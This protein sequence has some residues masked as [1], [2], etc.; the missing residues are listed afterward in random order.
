[1][2]FITAFKKSYFI[3]NAIQGVTRKKIHTRYQVIR[4]TTE[5]NDSHFI[6]LPRI[7]NI[8]KLY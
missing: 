7:N 2:T 6:Q 3:D 4:M 1:M 5:F 8:N